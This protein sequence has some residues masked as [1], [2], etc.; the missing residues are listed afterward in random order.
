[1]TSPTPLVPTNSMNAPIVFVSGSK[2]G[3]GKS[4][5]T[6]AVLDHLATKQQMT[7]L[8]DADTSNPDVFK[9][10]GRSLEA[11]QI[12]LDDVEGWIQL[13]NIADSPSFKTVVVNTP[14]RNNDGVRKHGAVLLGALKEL[15]RPLIT[16]WII[17]RQR[18]SLDLLSEYLDLTAG[19]SVVHVVQN[20]Y[21]GDQKKYELYNTSAI[22]DRVAGQGGKTL[23]LP[24]LADRV[25]DE[26][27]SKRITLAQAA[28][29]MKIGDRVELQRW[30]AAVGEMFGSINL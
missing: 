19:Q 10:Y 4:I 27:Y 2:G 14:A 1:M 20:G 26:L 18:D 12:D 16:L 5:T 28:S 29:Q 24:D 17:N 13:V 22:R 21:F 9:S 30:R 23:F 3:V 11:E 7:K 25:T 8:V 15:S 6:M